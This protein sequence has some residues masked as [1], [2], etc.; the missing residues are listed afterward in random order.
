MDFVR[1]YDVL[2]STTGLWVWMR[3]GKQD[4]TMIYVM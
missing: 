1:R 3:F 2:P 4:P